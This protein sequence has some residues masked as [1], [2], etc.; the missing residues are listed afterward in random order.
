MNT[1][2]IEGMTYEAENEYSA[3]KQAYPMALKFIQQKYLGNNTWQYKA[4]FAHG[5]ARVIV[6]K[7]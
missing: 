5:V 1:Y 4:V 6:T 3:V 2:E 7:I